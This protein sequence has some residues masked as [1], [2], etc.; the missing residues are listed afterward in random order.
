MPLVEFFLVASIG[1]VAG[2]AGGLLGIGG[3]I[4]IIPALTLLLGANQ[5]LYQASSMIVNVVI[6]A[7]ALP[8]HWRGGS[9]RREV[10][11][12]MLP[13]AIVA[14]LLGVGVSDQL[15]ATLLQRVFGAFLVWFGLSEIIGMLRG[16]D[17]TG[18]RPERTGWWLCSGIGAVMGFLGG[19]LGIGGGVVVVPLLRRFTGMPLR[20][21][22]GTT[23]ATM[24]V[25]ACIGSINKNLTIG[26]HP[27]PDGH[28][29]VDLLKETLAPTLD[30]TTVETLGHGLSQTLSWNDSVALAL[31]LGPAA[32]VGAFLGSHLN[33]RLPLRA[34]RL[35]LVIL[36]LVAAARMLGLVEFGALASP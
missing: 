18:D 20:H 21:C 29:D 24:L 28:L 17:R 7:A 3:S 25:T 19:L 34:L 32:I 4:I 35:I 5:H 6:A 27:T 11:L 14:M 33:Y 2:V 23:T 22:I 15:D 1:L 8:R 31:V 13:A 16:T 30:Q 9:V 10:L 26:R 12:R 36:I